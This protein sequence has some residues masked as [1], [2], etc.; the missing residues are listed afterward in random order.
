MPTNTTTRSRGQALLPHRSIDACYSQVFK[1]LSSRWVVSCGCFHLYFLI[2]NEV[3]HRSWLS[4]TWVFFLGNCSVMPLA[5]FST[6]WLVTFLLICKSSLHMM[7]SILFQLYLFRY[8]FLVFVFLFNFDSKQVFN[9][10]VVQI[11]QSFS[12]GFMFF[13]F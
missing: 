3:R 4:A 11:F 1:F 8:I 9:F 10:K 5:Y 7:D 2:T 6:G 13:V 12:L